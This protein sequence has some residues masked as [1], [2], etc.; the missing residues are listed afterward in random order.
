M[1]ESFQR[2]PKMDAINAEKIIT[3]YMR[4]IFGFALKRTKS[5]ADAED[6]S[7]EIVMKAY[8]ALVT[9][10]DVGDAEK[11]IWA[12]A[13]NTLA[14]YYRDTAR[15]YVGISVDEITETLWD[16]EE[17]PSE[18]LIREETAARLQKEIAYLSKLRRRIIIAYY[19]ENK[20]QSEIA[21]ELGVPEGTVK[22]NLYEAKKELKKGMDTMRRNE[23]K[24][25]PVKFELCGAS[26]SYGPQM[27]GSKNFESA[28]SQ[29]ILYAVREEPL[30]VNEIADAL[31]ISPVYVEDEAEKLAD[32]GFLTKHGSK[33]LCN[34]IIDEPT[35]ELFALEEEMYKKAAYLYA[36]A[37]YDE[38]SAD[39]IL[40]DPSVISC[41]KDKN[42]L[43]WSLIPYLASNCRPSDEKDKVSFEE[44]A[45]PR[46]DGG[47]NIGY[48]TVIH[49]DV[50]RPM[51][52]DAITKEFC[53][54][55]SFESP[56][57]LLWQTDTPWS[58]G[59]R[60]DRAYIHRT[61]RILSLFERE[62]DGGELSLDDCVFLAENG[63][64]R[65]ENTEYG[66]IAH[67]ECV[68]IHGKENADKLRAIGI[69]VRERYK[70]EFYALKKP[71]SKAV[72]ENT[73]KQMRKMQ[74]FVQQYLLSSDGW[75]LIY[76]LWELVE[77]GKLQVPEEKDRSSVTKIII[78]K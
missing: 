21:K 67:N 43:M 7:Q 76:C 61:E 59:K 17:D 19:Y 51:L 35:N 2:R 44:A 49:H 8:R 66:H 46:P 74:E 31:G 64:K 73:P 11:F 15:Q 75:F 55:G 9:K 40:D 65:I 27:I 26:G 47:V 53:G 18:K 48:A 62:R 41:E 70:K 78:L 52:W 68:V 14:N 30:T 60:I 16:G 33:Y 5:E 12:I 13:H 24:F 45:T 10:D 42:F 69:K 77:N 23:L 29:N 71:Y 56:K 20:K 39:P 4:P 58:G 22:W 25:N 36:N 50:K 38:L 54:A 63:F 6:L 34:I 28:I 32:N 1:V 57:S 37:L 72:I 3:E